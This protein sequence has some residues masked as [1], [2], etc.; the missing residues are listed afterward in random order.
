MRV[1]PAREAYR[2]WAPSYPPDTAVTHLEARVADGMTAP[3]A[4]GRLLDVG[5]GTGQR[6]GDLPDAGLRVGVDLAPAMLA[7]ARDRLGPDA[8][9]AAAELRAL[10][11]G[12]AA[13][14]TV[15]CRLVVGY[16]PDLAAAYAELARVCRPGGSVLVTD[17]HPDAAAAGHRR[18]FRE[19]ASGELREIESHPHSPAAHERAARAAEL[20]PV[21]RRD[22]EVGELVREFYERAGRLDMY[23]AQRGLRL[24]LALSFRRAEDRA[25]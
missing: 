4:G 14:D 20:V 16:V 3:T 13:F 8:P 6:L 19:A 17:L 18:S 25:R 10:P 23:E 22:G 21:A 12:A 24:V 11:F 7:R 5:C 9:L 1:L 15:W 2:L